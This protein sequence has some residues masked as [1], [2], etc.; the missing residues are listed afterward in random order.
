MNTSGN[1]YPNLDNLQMQNN[2]GDKTFNTPFKRAATHVAIA[3]FIYIKSVFLRL[4]NL[5]K[6]SF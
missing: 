2:K 5:F 1:K 3:Y 6:S 4:I